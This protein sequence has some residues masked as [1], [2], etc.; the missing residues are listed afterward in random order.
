MMSNPRRRVLVPT[1]FGIETSKSAA[2]ALAKPKP[3]RFNNPNC[4]QIFHG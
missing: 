3:P 1:Q 4:P 2:L